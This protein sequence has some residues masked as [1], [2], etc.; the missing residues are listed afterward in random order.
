MR[1]AEITKSP[2]K[3]GNDGLP[4]REEV[5]VIRIRLGQCFNG[6]MTRMSVQ[7]SKRE[8]RRDQKRSEHQQSLEEISPA[9]SAETAHKRVGNDDCSCN[10]HGNRWIQTN[11]GIEQCT[12]G[13]DT[14]SR[15]DCISDEKNNGAKD[16][17]HFARRFETVG[18]ILRKGNGII[19]SNG[20]TAKAG[21]LKDPAQRI[22]D[23]QANG[24]P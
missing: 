11:N 5:P 23:R 16:L 13:F 22:T 20:K 10:I 4:V 19:S 2:G 6:H 1:H 14:G 3:T 9:D 7:H 12:A 17:K 15:I 18:Q 8:D 24:N 21:S